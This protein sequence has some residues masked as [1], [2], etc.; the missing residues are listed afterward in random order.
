ML[1]CHHTQFIRISLAYHVKTSTASPNSEVYKQA[2]IHLQ[3]E[4]EYY[5]SRFSNWVDAHKIYVEALNSWLQKCIL[6]PQERRKGRKAIFPPRQA[7]SPPI[8]VVC[9]EW[10]AGLNSLAFEE[11]ICSIDSI[12]SI[13]RDTLEHPTEDRQSVLVEPEKIGP[14]N[15]DHDNCER[16]KILDNMKTCLTRLFD[17]LTKFSEASLKVYEDAKQ[18]NNA[19]RAAY[20]DPALRW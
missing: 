9:N 6:Q 5:S 14:E 12:V 8:F 7:I 11:L 16:F 4:F 2:L 1:E 17:R 19:A 10:L 3:H 18:S 13:I 20:A 15:K